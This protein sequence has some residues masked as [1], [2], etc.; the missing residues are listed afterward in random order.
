MLCNI[1]LCKISQ[2]KVSPRKMSL[3]CCSRSGWYRSPGSCTTLHLPPHRRQG[4]ALSHFSILAF[5]LLEVSSWQP[6][7][8]G[9]ALLPEHQFCCSDANIGRDSAPSFLFAYPAWW[10]GKRNFS[11]IHPFPW[12]SETTDP[13]SKG[14]GTALFTPLPDQSGERVTPWILCRQEQKDSL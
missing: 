13:T 6:S 3:S 10:H 12:S 1:L 11:S 4:T 2:I 8:G 5:S 14:R 7:F 9:T